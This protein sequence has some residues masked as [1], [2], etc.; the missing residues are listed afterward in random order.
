MCCFT[1]F[2]L[3][4]FFIL[5][6]SYSFTWKKITKDGPQNFLINV[7]IEKICGYQEIKR[8][9]RQVD[10]IL[11]PHTLS[12]LRHWVSDCCLGLELLFN[13]TY[14]QYFVAVSF[15]GGG[16]WSTRWKPLTCCK[17]R[18]FIWSRLPPK[19]NVYTSLCRRLLFMYQ[20]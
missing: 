14:T 15:I 11:N 13:A 3:F 18:A 5:F 6:I 20:G 19:F 16:N 2:L 1:F 4:F 9:S 10:M 7:W 17:S 8:D 12:W